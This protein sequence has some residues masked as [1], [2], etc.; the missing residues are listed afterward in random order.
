MENRVQN[1]Y[2]ANLRVYETIMNGYIM[3][4]REKLE[5][6]EPSNKLLEYPI[7]AMPEKGPREASSDSEFGMSLLSEAIDGTILKDLTEL[8]GLPIVDLM[9]VED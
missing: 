7:P 8:L 3:K 6:L 9:D 4:L 5:E 2:I 1:G